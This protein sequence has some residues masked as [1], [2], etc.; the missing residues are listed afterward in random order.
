MVITSFAIDGR[1]AIYRRVGGDR[2]GF[3]D[4][5][6][7]WKDETFPERVRVRAVA[8]LTPE[9]AVPV[10]ALLNKFTWAPNLK[11]SIAWTGHFRGS[12][13]RW[14]SIDGEL[15]VRAVLDAKENPVSRP[16]DKAKL[17]R[18][19]TAVKSPMD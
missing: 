5:A 19:P 1:V 7:I 17:S 14:D 8:A 10:R 12:P 11:S 13:V 18:R 2:R 16:V 4:N 6:S 15:V 9:T 3:S